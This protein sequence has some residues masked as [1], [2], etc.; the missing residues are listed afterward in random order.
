MIS[1]EQ[2]VSR[3]GEVL[4]ACAADGPTH[5]WLPW[6]T[7]QTKKG[8]KIYMISQ[9]EH[10]SLQP[11]LYRSGSVALSLGVEGGCA[12]SFELDLC[13]AC[14]AK[15]IP[16]LGLKLVLTRTAVV[17]VQAA[18]V[19]RVCIGKDKPAGVCSFM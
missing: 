17:A 5:G 11:E 8:V 2:L 4:Y 7:E 3:L 13:V 9:C 1:I 16:N 14:T 15:R 12:A 19:A 6:L 10:G 18:D